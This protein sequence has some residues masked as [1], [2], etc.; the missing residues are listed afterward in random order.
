MNR[1]VATGA[2][3]AGF[4]ATHASAQSW[5]QRPVRIIVPFASASSPDVL[6]RPVLR[7]SRPHPNR[8]PLEGG[9]AEDGAHS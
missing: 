1:C 8:L 6:A 5:P 4:V 3:I 9:A 2:V 7:L